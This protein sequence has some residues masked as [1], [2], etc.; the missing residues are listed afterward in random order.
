MTIARV[1]LPVA[2][3]DA[4]DYWVP[5][6][7]AV[8]PGAIVRVHLGRRAMVGV[9]VDISATS[10]VA[11]D[12]LQPVGEMLPDIPPLPADVLALA[13]FVSGYYQEPLG[14]VLAQM[15]PPI[16]ASGG[17]SRVATSGQAIQLTDAGRAALAGSLTRDSA[18]R[19]AFLQFVD[20]P[21]GSLPAGAIAALPAT[22]RRTLRAWCDKGYLAGVNPAPA[23]SPERVVLNAEQRSAVDA[24]TAAHGSFAPF[25]LQGVTGSGK[26]DVY[27]EAARAC[28]AAGRQ[29]LFLVPEIN[30]TPQL[31][32]RIADAL[33]GRRAVTLHSRLAAGERRRNW[34]QAAEGD[35]DLLLGTRLAVFA[36]LPRL[37]LIVIDEEHDPS[38]KQ[39][40]GVRYHGRDVAIWRARQRSVP[41]VLGSATPS[42][43]TL[44]QAQRGRYRHLRLRQRAIA[45]ARLPTCHFVSDKLPG[46]LEGISAPLLAAIEARLER[47]EQSLLFVNRRGFAPSLL[48]S[49]CG[50]Q[51][52]C[53]RC[54]ARLV[55]HRDDRML[56]CHHCG[57]AERL[58][59]ACPDCGN[60]DLLPLGHGTQRLERAL[61]ER[62]PGARIARVDRDSTQRKGAF[63][64]LREQVEAGALDI[65]VG[66]QMLA[67]GHDF[68]RLT[69][70]GVVGADNALFSADF[71]ATERLAAL[72]FQVAGRAGRALLPGEVIVQTDFAA[73]A[74]FRALAAQDYESF[75]ATLFAERRAAALPP[76]THLALLAAEAPHRVAVDTFLAAAHAAGTAL[77]RA[78]HRA[79][80]VFPPV[81]AALARRAGAE[82]ALVVAQSDDRGSLQR[83]L[84]QWRAAIA[85]IPGRQVRW[86][87]DVDPLGFA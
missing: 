6:G 37:G 80:E 18:A 24:I 85:A 83:F 14:L 47:R 36:P 5:A 79:V 84:A 38:F 1:A 59:R 23:A 11:A 61:T 68:P 17:A 76:F 15:L 78:A 39:Q 13:Q 56:R 7:I 25:L 66:T 10:D 74:V 16:G 81:P 29:A 50:W 49:G 46:T 71:R 31:A 34:R 86:S 35:A 40:D 60:V 77:T 33:P 19:R 64:G 67:K 42:L 75:A 26:T 8:A 2:T 54:S 62:F 43:E 4:F 27:L 21:D 3:E 9:V 58:P 72:L 57:H 63:A 65:L 52:A 41:V 12:R 82:R 70:V 87:L 28:I 48:C 44:L 51:A 22:T 55:V 20:A 32:Q 45:P 69:L 30:L 73:H 53:H